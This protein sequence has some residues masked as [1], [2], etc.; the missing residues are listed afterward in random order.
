MRVLTLLPLLFVNSAS[1][2]PASD[3]Q[4][5]FGETT[6][7]VD[8]SRGSHVYP[9]GKDVG[10]VIHHAENVSFGDDVE[11]WVEENREYVKQNGLICTSFQRSGV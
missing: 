9:E 4:I 8:T 6:A 1:A 5:V 3:A 10:T 2:A 7:R 11:S